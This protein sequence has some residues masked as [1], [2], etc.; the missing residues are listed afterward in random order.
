M[1]NQIHPLAFVDKKVKLGDNNVIGPY[2]YITGDTEIGD[3]NI[4]QSH[5]VI[6]TPAEHRD[7]MRS[8]P[9]KTYIGSNNIF[10]EFATI[11]AGSSDET[12]LADDIIMQKGSYVGHDSYIAKKVNLSCNVLIGGH[13]HIME[14]AN[15]GLGSMCHQFSVIGAYSMIGMGSVVT[16]T[17]K[18]EPGK[19]YVGSPARFLKENKIGLERNG[20]QESD[21]FDLN[22]MFNSLYKNRN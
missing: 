21:L 20:I 9:G 17:S 11:N 3:N 12:V 2:C 6:G 14:G 13:C 8:D 19:I 1:A 18:I 10:R 15:F 7:Y 5:C 22:F 16:K 4:F